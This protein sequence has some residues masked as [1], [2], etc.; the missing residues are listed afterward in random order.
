MPPSA[1]LLAWVST[2]FHLDYARN[3]IIDTEP[4]GM[5]TPWAHVPP[6]VHY[7]LWQYRGF[8]VRPHTLDLERVAG[9]DPTEQIT[10]LRS[11]RFGLKLQALASEA[12]AGVPA[13]VVA[14]DDE[15]ILLAVTRMPD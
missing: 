12:D 4:A 13:R 14:K 10:A 11:Y 6:D 7:V 8:A 3:P 1:P 9:H 5:T 15:F 2:S